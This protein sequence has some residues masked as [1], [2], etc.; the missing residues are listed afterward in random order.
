MYLRFCKP[1]SL[2][3]AFNTAIYAPWTDNQACGVWWWQLHLRLSKLQ[4]QL[5]RQGPRP[6]D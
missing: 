5:Q 4:L 2:L 3:L 6:H 1:V